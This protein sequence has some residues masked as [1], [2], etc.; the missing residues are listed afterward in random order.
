MF[1]L[2]LGLLHVLVS[3][4]G[5]LLVNLYLSIYFFQKPS[6]DLSNPEWSLGCGFNL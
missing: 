6:G 5:V 2:T 3:R 4:L 1:S